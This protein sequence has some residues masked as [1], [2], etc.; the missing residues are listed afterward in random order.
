MAK[1]CG[2]CQHENLDSA[3]FCAKC[4]EKLFV[5]TGAEN[6]APWK[7]V[8]L[9]VLIILLLVACGFLTKLVIIPMAEP[10][11][12]KTSTAT[13]VA[14]GQEVDTP[15]P[16]EEPAPTQKASAC[17]QTGT[18]SFLIS[19]VDAPYTSDPKGADAIRLVKLDFSAMEVTVV[20]LP[21]DLWVTTSSLDYLDISANRLGLTYYYAKENPPAST[22][23][24]VYGTTILA[25]TIYDNFGFVPDHYITVHIDNFDDMVDAIGGLEVT[26]PQ[27]YKSN[28]Y[29]F[30]QGL[31]L[32]NGDQTLEYVSNF[33]KD[34]EWN[35]FNR[36]DL[37]L[38][39]IYKKV[40]SPSILMSL[41]GLI[42]EFGDT[43]TT[44]LS[45][46]E[47]I[48]LSCMLDD[49]SMEDIHYVEVDQTMVTKQEDS[50]VLQPNYA[51]ISAMLDEI[52]K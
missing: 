32:L 34:T 18:M 36:Q 49:V 46:M 21:R 13:P 23:E 7:K 24:V 5:W 29:L 47:I 37:I 33:I 9:V 52:F 22:D 16:T 25:Q 51:E 42:S 17:K 50:P 41:P 26:I 15:E 14:S 40:T 30:P 8:G 12:V 2:N 20:A 35:R 31:L 43:V 19:G 45:I 39:S 44:D 4:G 6:N 1:I 27:E 28:N 10:L 48:D 38:K 3:D 11:F